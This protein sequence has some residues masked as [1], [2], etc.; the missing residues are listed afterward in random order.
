MVKASFPPVVASDARLLILGSLPGD[1][2]LAERRY[3]AHPQNQFWRLLSPVVRC[4]LIA[5]EYEHRLQALQDRGVALWDVIATARR[6]GSSDAAI[7]DEVANDLATLVRSLP[8]L[9]AIAF[10][11]G[12]AAAIGRLLL[13]G[14]PVS[15]VDLPSSSPLHTIGLAAKQSAW[16][17]LA[18][19]LG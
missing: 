5:L 15:L 13:A 1:R 6:V 17:A 8:Q 18:D 9:R 12:K 16:S 3:Y 4:D 19:Y 11:G 2:S 7:Q 14:E 10:N